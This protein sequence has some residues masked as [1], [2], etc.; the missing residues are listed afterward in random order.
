MGPKLYMC[1]YWDE[2]WSP[3]SVYVYAWI[4]VGMHCMITP[5]LVV[6]VYWSLFL[7]LNF[8]YLYPSEIVK[9]HGVV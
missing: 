4:D 1:V 6:R 3:C 7:H 2:G 8:I 9:V 5:L